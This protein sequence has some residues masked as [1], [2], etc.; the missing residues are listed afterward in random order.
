MDAGRRERKKAATHSQII[1]VAMALFEQEGFDQV[2]ME[3]I[4]QAADVSKATL[5]KYFPVKEAIL[6]AYIRAQNQ[7]CHEQITELLAMFPDTRTR[8]NEL[9][10]GLAGWF[11]QHK[12]YVAR[13][14]AYR[15]SAPQLMNRNSPRSGFDVHLNM[16]LVKGQEQGD[17]T[18]G[19]PV[20]R[21]VASL[22][23]MMLGPILYWLNVPGLELHVLFSE[24]IALFLDGAAD[25]PE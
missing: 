8:L 17:V 10:G 25:K 4:A 2:T 24:Q 20:D 15:M 16:V 6:A 5:Y 21:L 7:A 23:L 3:R 11:T 9:Y 19:M 14:V 18:P 22:E 1:D 12:L 13:Y